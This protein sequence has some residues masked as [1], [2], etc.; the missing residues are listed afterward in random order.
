MSRLYI[1]VRGF[2][3]NVI[4][5][6]PAAFHSSKFLLFYLNTNLFVGTLKILILFSVM[7]EKS[8]DNPCSKFY[9]PKTNTHLDPFIKN[10][11]LLSKPKGFHI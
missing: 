7:T 6:F 5:L 10:S 2:V 3:G 8:G 4:L 1:L 9:Y 11:K